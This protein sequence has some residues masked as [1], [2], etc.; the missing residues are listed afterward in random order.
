MSGRL[1]YA[2]V[3]HSANAHPYLPARVQGVLQ[4]LL[5]SVLEQRR[6]VCV[7]TGAGYGDAHGCSAVA[8]HDDNLVGRKS[9]P[10]VTAICPTFPSVRT[11]LMLV[12]L[13]SMAL[14]SART[15]SGNLFD[16]LWM[17]ML[18]Q[19]TSTGSPITQGFA[20]VRMTS[21]W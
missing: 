12:P 1:Q 19:N 10:S 21:F 18:K 4:P 5:F 9:R 7:P 16:R 13:K 15:G 3:A 8:L 17:K 6:C 14:C 20:S 2:R 11:Q